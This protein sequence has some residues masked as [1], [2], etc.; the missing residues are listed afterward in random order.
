MAVKG[1][2]VEEL[3]RSDLFNIFT[4]AVTSWNEVN[5]EWPAEAIALYTPVW[6]AARSTSSV[7]PCSARTHETREARFDAC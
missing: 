6:T 3:K 1:S 7:R 5:P 4:G 2:F